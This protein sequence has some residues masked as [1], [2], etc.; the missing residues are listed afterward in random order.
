[1]VGV[2]DPPCRLQLCR[3]VWQVGA[4]SGVTPVSG[5]WSLIVMMANVQADA[6]NWPPVTFPESRTLLGLL[7]I[8]AKHW[9]S[10]SYH[11]IMFFMY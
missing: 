9:S 1:M 8:L 11:L 2:S 10:K 4:D 6:N 7:A 3:T 5:L